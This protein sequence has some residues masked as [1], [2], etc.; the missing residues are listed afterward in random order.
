[1]SNDLTVNLGEVT[2]SM[3]AR[4]LEEFRRVLRQDIYLFARRAEKLTFPPNIAHYV[5]LGAALQA[6]YDQL[7]V[8]GRFLQ[9]RLTVEEE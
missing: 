9:Q 4:Y 6:V 2:F 3:P 7:P 5:I 8:D 1:M